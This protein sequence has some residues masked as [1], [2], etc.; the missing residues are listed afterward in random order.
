MSATKVGNGAARLFENDEIDLDAI[1][2]SACLLRDLKAL[3]EVQ[4]MARKTH[5]PEPAMQA[6]AATDLHLMEACPEPAERGSA[7]KIDTRWSQIEELR[8]LG[9]A[10]ADACLADYRRDPGRTSTVSDLLEA[11]AA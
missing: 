6:L 3:T 11:V 5:S 10:T 9:R 7:S 8:A 2:A 1:I 4:A